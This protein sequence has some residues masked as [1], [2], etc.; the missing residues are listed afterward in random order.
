MVVTEWLGRSRIAVNALYRKSSFD[1]RE[2]RSRHH[3]KFREQHVGMPRPPGALHTPF[4]LEDVILLIEKSGCFDVFREALFNLIRDALGKNDVDV[5][6]FGRPRVETFLQ[7]ARG[8]V[9]R[10]SCLRR[11]CKVDAHLRTSKIFRGVKVDIDAKNR[12]QRG[13]DGLCE[14]FGGVSKELNKLILRL[15]WKL[16]DVLPW[17]MKVRQNLSEGKVIKLAEMTLALVV[18][19]KNLNIVMEPS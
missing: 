5:F 3:V 11:A 12:S 6:K 8:D 2:S 16:I 1:I 15:K 17:Q 14:R 18:Q 13:K 10:G 7:C 19:G 4:F 9:G